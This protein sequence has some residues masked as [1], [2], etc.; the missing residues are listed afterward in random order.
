[1]KYIIL[2]LS[3]LLFS[4][5]QSLSAE[6]T[7][8]DDIELINSLKA[9]VYFSITN[10]EYEKIDEKIRWQTDEVLSDFY[11]YKDALSSFLKENGIKE[12]FTAKKQIA[13]QN[14]TK[15]K[16]VFKRSNFDHV[17]GIIMVDKNKE[18]R[19]FLGVGTDIDLIEEFKTYFE[20]K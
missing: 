20:I 15:G 18:P 7:N 12:Y 3:I 5:L 8:P 10:Q 14:S 1:M 13:F 11:H 9:V 16:T 19:V 17:V 2:I 6:T 4:P